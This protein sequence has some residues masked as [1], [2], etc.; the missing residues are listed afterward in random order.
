M[1]RL[2]LETVFEAPIE[3]V[4]LHPDRRQE[5]Q[6]TRHF[7]SPRPRLRLHHHVARDTP[8]DLQRL[9]RLLTGTG[10]QLVLSG[11]GAR[12]LCHLGALR[13]L[14]HG[15]QQPVD[16]AAAHRAAIEHD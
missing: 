3:R 7:L 14:D 1:T 16:A 2:R 11:G 12:A 9:A 15:N 13:A 5:P 8:S 4:M 10:V 6:G